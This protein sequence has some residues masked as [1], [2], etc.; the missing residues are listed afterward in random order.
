ML[1]SLFCQ[2]SANNLDLSVSCATGAVPLYRTLRAND[3]FSQSFECLLSIFYIIP[4]V[5]H[6]P[7]AKVRVL[8]VFF[9]AF[10]PIVSTLLII[11][12]LILQ[13]SWKSPSK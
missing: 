4:V 12:L 5:V 9:E 1:T 6:N 8:S 3:C 13:S 7:F 11:A 10:T 2:I